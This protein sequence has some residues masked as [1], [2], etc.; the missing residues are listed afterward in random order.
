MT[1]SFSGE[2][3]Y[4]HL[5]VLTTEIGPRHGGS[6]NEAQA[7]RYIRDHFKSLG[8]KTR[9]QRYPIY[10]FENASGRLAIPGGGEIPCIPIPISATTSPRGITRSTVFL[11]GNDAVHLDEDVRDKIVVMFDS[12]REDL[13]RRFNAYGPAGLVSIQTRPGMAHLRKPGHAHSNR[14]LG[15]VPSVLLTLEDGL[16]LV[17]NM[18]EKLTIKVSTY[19]E[20]VT[21]GYNVIADL[22]GS[23]PDDE[24]LVVCAHYD[25]VWAGPGA[26]DNGA[27]AA[28][29]MELARVYKE[30]GSRRNLRFIAFGGE[31]MGCWGSKSYVKKLHDT[32]T[33]AKK[34]KDF[35]RDG[36]RSELDLHRFLINLDMM[37]PLYGTSIAEI[38]GDNDI[39]AS[40]RLL[41][42]ELRYAIA[43]RENVVYSSDNMAFNYA[44]I[45]SLSFH[46]GPFERVGGHTSEDTI[47][48]CSAEG[49]SHICSF[50]EAWIDRYVQL[51][52]T[53]PFSRKLPDLAKDAVGKWFGERNPLDYE[54]YGPEKKHASVKQA[55]KA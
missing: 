14:K 20:R 26:F 28:S 54:V 50:I 41:A 32:D 25:S 16:E 27:G 30:K 51:L 15:S 35:E 42:N 22:N 24:V 4:E 39:A 38:L 37:G 2:N 6:K 31:E 52:H 8:L 5:R 46:R 47:K 13:Q 11:E 12:F 43:I 45:P 55:T 44:G 21:N 19:E 40:V 1:S 36:L 7:A 18:P 17:K 53:F 49:L 48:S 9:L 23:F 33:A 29:V 3:A 34:N 10:S